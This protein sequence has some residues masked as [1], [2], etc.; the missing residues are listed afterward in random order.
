MVSTAIMSATV[1]V[2][3][4]RGRMGQPPDRPAGECRLMGHRPTATIDET[5]QASG[6][7]PAH[8]EVRRYARE[9][10]WHR[11]PDGAAWMSVLP[12]VIESAARHRST[13]AAVS[14]YG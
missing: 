13:T 11:L 1:V 7:F 8:S 9:V 14:A 6:N 2:F 5:R 4:L 3:V 10:A 12:E